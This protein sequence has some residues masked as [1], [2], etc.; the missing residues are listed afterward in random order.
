MTTELSHSNSKVTQQRWL[1]E[2]KNNH[3]ELLHQDREFARWLQ[4]EY[5]P[6]AGGWA[7]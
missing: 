7:Y 6:I 2:Y 4:E 5:V 3:R 1:Q